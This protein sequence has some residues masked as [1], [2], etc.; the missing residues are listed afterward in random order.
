MAKNL[1]KIL[2]KVYLKN[3]W[4]NRYKD[5]ASAFD[6]GSDTLRFTSS[7]IADCELFYDG[8]LYLNE[9]KSHKGLNIPINCILGNKESNGKYKREK[10]IKDLTKANTF[11]GIEANIIVFFSE[12]ERC[13]LLNIEHFNTFIKKEERKSIPIIYFEEF[14]IEIEVKKL[15]VN[16]RYN[17]IK[18]LEEVK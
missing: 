15:Q 18:L 1:K 6:G 17:I 7:N 2:K 11:E 12:K 8:K 4:Y 9:L 5:S 13:F 10:Q 14:G 3:V 16:Y